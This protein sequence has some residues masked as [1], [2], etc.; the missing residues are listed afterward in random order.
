MTHLEVMDAEGA[1]EVGAHG[2]PPRFEVVREL[3]AG[4]FGRVYLARDRVHGEQV[5]LKILARR[6]P[7]ALKRFKTEFRS[8]ANLV[9]DNLVSLFELHQSDDGAAGWFFTMEHIEGRPFTEFLRPERGLGAG[10]PSVT[11]DVPGARAESR[12]VPSAPIHQ[13]DEG[14]HP[15]ASYDETLDP[16][17]LPDL[18]PLSKPLPRPEP[19]P[20]TPATPRRV[21]LPDTSRTPLD[22]TP[23]APVFLHPQTTQPATLP[24]APSFFG[25]EAP[26]EETAQKWSALRPAPGSGSGLTF[27][28]VDGQTRLANLNACFGQLVE[29]LAWLHSSGH[30]HRDVKPSN[31]LVDG[32]GRVKILDFGL[33]ARLHDN[34]G[35]RGDLIV[36][37]PAFMA[38]ELCAG[39]PASPASDWYSVGVML[40]LVLT[41]HL[42]FA[43]NSQ[44]SLLAKQALSPRPPRELVDVPPELDELCVRLLAI[45]PLE[46]PDAAA[47]LRVFSSQ[48]HDMGARTPSDVFVGRG[49][50]VASLA[51]VLAATSGPSTRVALVSAPSG[52]GKT[53]LVR[54]VLRELERAQVQGDGHKEVV[55]LRSRCFERGTVRYRALDGAIDDL[56]G[57]LVAMPPA[58]RDTLVPAGLDRDAL[59]RLFPVLSLGAIDSTADT[60]PADPADLRRRALLALREL[61][62]AVG[63]QRHLVFAIDDAQW[64]DED[65]VPLVAE[66]MRHCEARWVFTFRPEGRPERPDDAGAQRRPTT[67]EQTSPF[68]LALRRDILPRLDAGAIK[69]LTLTPLPMAEAEALARE[70]LEHWNAPPD[71]ARARLLAQEAGGHPLLISELARISVLVDKTRVETS[72]APSLDALLAARVT[73]LPKRSRAAME[74][75]AVAG[76]PI[77]P[78]LLRVATGIDSSELNRLESD[79]LIATRPGSDGELAMCWHDRVRE[80]TLGLLS[81]GDLAQRHLE[82]AQSAQSV[83]ENDPLFLASHLRR[84]VATWLTGDGGHGVPD[85][86]TLVTTFASALVWGWTATERARAS[87]AFDQAASIAGSLLVL[88][89]QAAGPSSIIAEAEIEAAL[90]GSCGDRVQ[91]A[92]AQA[93][94]LANAGRG[95]LAARSFERAATLCGDEVA[96]RKIELK[97]A[98]QYLFAGAFKEGE[99]TIRRVMERAGLKVAQGVPGAMTSFLWESMRMRLRGMRFKEVAESEVQPA[100]LALIDTLWSTTI[101]LSMAWPL[102]SQAFQQR[103]IHMALDAGEPWR[104][105]RAMSIELAFSGLPGGKGAE[106]SQRLSTL[107]HE[108]ASRSQDPYPEAFVTMSDGGVHWLC[109]RW[110]AAKEAVEKAL[111]VYRRDCVGVTW[112]KDTAE[113]VALQALAHMGDLE[114]LSQRADEVLDDAVERGDLYLETQVRTR[115]VP[116]FD[117]R[118]GQPR[119]A[120]EGLERALGRWSGSGF[121]IVHYWALVNRVNTHLFL[122]DVNEAWAEIVRH[123]AALKRSFLL[124]GQY[125]RVQWHELRARVGVALAL[126]GVPQGEKVARQS[127]RV[128]TKEAMPWSDAL[129]ALVAAQLASVGRSRVPAPAGFDPGF[130]A[131]A[132]LLDKVDMHLHAVSARAALSEPPDHHELMRL[133]IADPQ[134]MMSVF[135]SR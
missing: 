16:P 111:V 88:C 132:D 91:L 28:G 106:K 4:G 99:A 29:A 120:L 47:M 48:Q 12:S 129:A 123:E 110:R 18:L 27:E 1:A 30:L 92:L 64:A 5:A 32:R 13:G 112:E 80:S 46:R 11:L 58:Q 133:G 94:S 87:L 113:F 93:E 81:V 95:V 23:D 38:P 79:H 34:S 55:I 116:L 134:A 7:H 78:R 67:R 82:L 103:H 89:E 2:L 20:A 59:A 77:S 69:E 43:G 17:D 35:Q 127:H 49:A 72:A 44:V 24:T 6:D 66:L 124:M 60:G 33:V 70:A 39:L 61:L 22:A 101:G 25:I 125:Y 126:K 40:Y 53:A 107:A 130:G 3:G 74:L 37:T 62:A 50:E 83:G 76:E 15:H 73:E 8:L 100:T 68:L 54:H 84:A 108:V 63:R 19:S 135:V 117:L 52:F 57:V 105:A 75:V 102:G 121:Q 10:H 26:D 86:Q 31:V 114:T 85:R 56:A 65:S 109:G 42:P 90:Q 131:A 122:G 71:P 21:A 41:G 115:I 9:H 98:E 119:R 128:L 104:V 96:C 118:D 45:N 97:A 14:D 51:S 36:G